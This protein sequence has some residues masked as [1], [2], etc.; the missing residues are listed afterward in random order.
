MLG[1]SPE[2][3]WFRDDFTIDIADVAFFPEKPRAE[4]GGPRRDAAVAESKRALDLRISRV[5]LRDV[6][7]SRFHRVDNTKQDA[8]RHKE[9]A[10]RRVTTTSANAVLSSRWAAHYKTCS[11]SGSR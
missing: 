7:Q 6:S 2:M 8:A 10:A 9:G 4:R 5:I 11:E 3:L 1:D